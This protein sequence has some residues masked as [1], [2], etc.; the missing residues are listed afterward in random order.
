[1]KNPYI[2]SVTSLSFNVLVC[3]NNSSSVSF[4]VEYPSEQNNIVHHQTSRNSPYRLKFTVFD[5]SVSVDSGS[6]VDRNKG[7]CVSTNESTEL[8]L[9]VYLWLNPVAIASYLSLPYQE[10]LADQYEYY[11]CLYLTKK[12][13]LISMNIIPVSTL[14]RNTC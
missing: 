14:P 1:M 11:T 9:I 7:I 4:T 6:F 2:N 13:L 5:A 10:I 3:K 12:Y 8:F